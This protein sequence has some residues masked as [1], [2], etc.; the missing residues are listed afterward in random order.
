MLN[1]TWFVFSLK[2]KNLLLGTV[3]KQQIN[4]KTLRNADYKLGNYAICTWKHDLSIKLF[5]DI[6]SGLN[7]QREG[8]VVQT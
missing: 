5:C 3:T 1:K 7:Q 2:Q 6:L 8:P 4:G